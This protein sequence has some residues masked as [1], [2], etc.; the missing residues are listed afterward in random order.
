M[1]LNLSQAAWRKSSYSG[2]AQ[3]CVEVADGL[4]GAVG[5]RDSKDPDGPALILAPGAWR[6]LTRRVKS[7]ELDLTVLPVQSPR[8]A[9]RD[10]GSSL[11]SGNEEGSGAAGRRFR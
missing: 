5:V 9:P 7:G 8:R 1:K 11:L 4:P 3:N 2:Q 6:A 10:R